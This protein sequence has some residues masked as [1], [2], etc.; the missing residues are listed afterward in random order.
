MKEQLQ[1]LQTLAPLS[2]GEACDL[3]RAILAPGQCVEQLAA[4]LA[5]L[6]VRVLRAEELLAFRS[7]L[8]DSAN[9]PTIDLGSVIDLCGTGGDGRDS[10]NISTAAAFVVAACGAK[11]AKHGNYGAS[12]KVGSSNILESLG[13]KF[14]ADFAEIGSQLEQAGITFLHAPLFHPALKTIAPV[15]RALGVR[16]IFN[17]LGPLVN[18]VQPTVQLVGVYSPQVA[19]VYQLVLA[20]AGREAAAGRPQRFAVLH[21]LDGYDEISLT[22]PTQILTDVGEF[23]LTPADFGCARV[24]AVS[25]KGAQTLADSAKLFRSVLAGGGNPELSEVVA[26]NAGLALWLW[27]A[28]S[29]DQRAALGTDGLLKSCV[30]EA[31]AVLRSGAAAELLERVT[32]L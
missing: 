30:A 16:T 10:F 25:L 13:V 32:K 27:R 15:R 9:K 14:Q 20:A 26:A 23:E 3:I 22:A 17:L 19:R 1:R 8:L 21:S 6:N 24:S 29:Q 5:L 12:S 7:V 2:H 11:V 18:P 31:R 28:E 4:A